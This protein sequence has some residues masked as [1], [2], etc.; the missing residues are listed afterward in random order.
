MPEGWAGTG[1]L[2]VH[3]P[4]D[5]PGI[6]TIAMA[7]RPSGLPTA[8]ALRLMVRRCA[9][10]S[11]NDASHRQ[12]N[13]V[14]PLPVRASCVETL[15]AQAPQHER[16]KLAATQQDKS[17]H[18]FAIPRRV[19]ARVL[20]A[21]QPSAKQRGRRECRVMASPMVRLQQKSRRRHHR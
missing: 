18:T 14:A 2:D 20:Q 8:P 9:A 1:R 21:A 19:H 6:V 17:K 15:A 3:R 10:P 5:T 16:K 7:P 4:R 13:H 11:L 12:E